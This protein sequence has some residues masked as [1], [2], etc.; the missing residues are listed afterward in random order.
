MRELLSVLHTSMIIQMRVAARVSDKYAPAEIDKA[1]EP[2][3]TIP[4][5]KEPLN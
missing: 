2:V 3:R 1:A 5:S 4:A